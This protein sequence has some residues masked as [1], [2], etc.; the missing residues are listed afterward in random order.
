[1]KENNEKQVMHLHK[2]SAPEQV[3]TYF[4]KVFELK[5]SGNKFPV[6]FDEVWPLVY[7]AKNKAVNELTETTDEFGN[8]RYFKDVDY[9]ALDQM[10][11][12]GPGLSKKTKY[13]LSVPCLEWFIARKV[14]A[15]FDVYRHVF[16]SAVENMK[17]SHLMDRNWLTK[18]AYCA[19]FNTTHNSFNGLMSSYKTEFLYANGIWYM[20]ED[21]ANQQELRKRFET[22]KQKLRKRTEDLLQLKI[23]FQE[24]W[25]K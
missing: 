24:G 11:K 17:F 12:A 19:K 16:E 18:E 7:S 2:S 5:Q 13:Y 3:K 25:A 4:E 15:V 1:M 23:N 22:N 21:L 9:Q 6:D 20:S 14:R 8:L 10:V